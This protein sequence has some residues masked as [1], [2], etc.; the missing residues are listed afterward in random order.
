V[1]AIWLRGSLRLLGASRAYASDPHP[2]CG[3]AGGAEQMGD[4]MSGYENEPHYGGPEVTWWR[5]AL[6]AAA[7]L[8]LSY[9]CVQSYPNA[10][11]PPELKGVASVIDGD[12]IEIHGERVRLSGFD[13]PERGRE[14]IDSSGATVRVYQTTSNALSE[15][16]GARTVEC[17]RS[18]SDDHSRTVATCSVGGT[19]LGSWMVEN[20]HAWDWP[21]YSRG[22]YAPEE[23]RA[24]AAKRG[25]W[26]LTCVD[27]LG[28][29][30]LD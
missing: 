19:D 15:F 30:K 7:C 2:A 26:G 13:A 25:L 17:E 9:G 5:I 3:G 22:K 8:A 29:R 10:K 20:G 27:L 14:C 16:I 12:T 18:G 1:T 28:D 4:I 24:R 11:N 6:S 23:A 21:K